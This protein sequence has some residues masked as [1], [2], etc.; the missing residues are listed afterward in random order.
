MKAT[1]YLEKKKSLFRPPKL[2]RKEEVS[3]SMFAPTHP[4]VANFEMQQST[5]QYKNYIAKRP[6]DNEMNVLKEK[7][8]MSFIK[9]ALRSNKSAL[10][11][12]Y[13]VQQLLF[14]GKNNSWKKANHLQS[15][16]IG[17]ELGNVGRAAINERRQDRYHRRKHNNKKHRKMR[18][19]A[20]SNN[21]KNYALNNP[22]NK[23]KMVNPYNQATYK[24]GRKN[25]FGQNKGKKVGGFR[26][27]RYKHN[28]SNKHLSVSTSSKSYQLNNATSI[29]T[30]TKQFYS[31]RPPEKVSSNKNFVGRNSSPRV[32]KQQSSPNNNKNNNQK[33]E[34]FEGN[35]TLD[36]YFASPKLKQ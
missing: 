5:S 4:V 1:E 18:T 10:S 12:G 32:K 14:P 31:P 16:N 11:Q 28:N 27:R 25:H 30:K 35:I 21:L 26:N 9:Q 29:V 22:Y 34:A 13:K 2:S 23:T 33:E 24:R 17:I 3:K 8:I 36:Q 19:N 15:R 20:T 6:F 7:G